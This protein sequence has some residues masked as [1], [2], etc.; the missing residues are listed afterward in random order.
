MTRHRQF[1][2]EGPESR[3]HFVVPPRVGPNVR[4][5]PTGD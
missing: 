1:G 5:R 3:L 4:D 2:D